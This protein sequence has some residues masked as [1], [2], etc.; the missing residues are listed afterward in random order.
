MQAPQTFDVQYALCRVP[1]FPLPEESAL[2]V[3]RSSLKSQRAIR[4]DAKLL[5]A[6]IFRETVVD[7]ATPEPVP[8][9]TRGKMPVEVVDDV[10]TLTVV[11]HVAVQ[12]AAEKVA[13][14]PAGSDDAEN[15]TETG[16]PARRTAVMPVVAAC[17]WISDRVDAVAD[18]EIEV[19]MADVVNVESVE[20][21]VP[22]LEF[23]ELTRK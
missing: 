23:V 6:A 1:V 12:V 5:A 2:T 7:V 16:K 11:L 10:A 13:V 3:P 8:L 15:A 9:M 21:V 4:P 19:G 22:P 14:T 17:P 18:I 20:T